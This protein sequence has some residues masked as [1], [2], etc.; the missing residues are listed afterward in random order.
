MK[1]FDGDIGLQFTLHI[2]NDYTLPQVIGLAETAHQQGFDQVWVNDN[3]CHRNIFVVLAAIAAKVPIKL[4]TA[5]LVPYFRNPVDLA[6]SI[7]TI[8]ELTDGREF[9]IG[10]ARGAHAIAG[11][12]VEAVKP[13]AAV[14]ETVSSIKALL[15]GSTINYKD[16]PNIGS[17]F[18]LNPD[19]EFK[20]EF[21]PRSPVRFY[22]GGNGPRILNIAARIMDGILIGGYYIPLVRTG[23]LAAMLE[24]PRKLSSEFQPNNAQYDTCELN[25]S[26]SR[27]R[28]AAFQFA[29]PYVSH[30]LIS[31]KQ[32][33][34]T[35]DDFQINFVEPNLVK[36]VDE[37]FSKGATV[38]Q[39]AEIIP[40]EAVKSCFVVGEPD[41][42]KEQIL[43][44]MEDAQQLNF[45]QVCL[46]K[47]GPN[48]GEAIKLLRENVLTG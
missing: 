15:S 7:A 44:L 35:D 43:G 40:D 48:Y 39:V 27:D 26:I 10:I 21:E 36:S 33:G 8:T 9:S 20:L 45:G 19:W 42:C 22:S 18:H 31:L 34:F 1:H 29:K 12:Q 32:M 6:D 14:K 25:V 17:Y 13:L 47:L 24:Q 16:Y 38:S 46:A 11:N 23:R 4:G 30:M 41:E 28:D 37:A 2:A 3:L 5:I